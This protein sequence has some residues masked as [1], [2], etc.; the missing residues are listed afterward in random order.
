MANK[1]IEHIKLFN[2]AGDV[3]ESLDIKDIATVEFNSRLEALSAQ[4][5][6]LQ[7]KYDAII[8]KLEYDEPGQ[9]GSH[10]SSDNA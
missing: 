6:E 8:E 4:L 7:A 10:D 1:V 2:P 5:A 3:T 9:H